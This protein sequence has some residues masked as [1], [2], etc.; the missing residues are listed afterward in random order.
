MRTNVCVPR[1]PSRLPLWLKRLAR[2]EIKV[3][4]EL[5]LTKEKIVGLRYPVGTIGGPHLTLRDGCESDDAFGDNT[6]TNLVLDV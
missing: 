3:D 1:A 4:D 6:A 2:A 5:I